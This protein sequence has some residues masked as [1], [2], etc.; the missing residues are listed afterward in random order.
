[1][2]SI[3]APLIAAGADGEQVQYRQGIVRAWNPE[4]G[5]NTI[6][7]AG[8]ILTDLPF[9]S[10]VEALATQVGDVVG[11]LTVR[12]Q[13]WIIGRIQVTP[14]AIVVRDAAGGVS[15]QIDRTPAGGGQVTTFH[16]NGTLHGRLGELTNLSTGERVG[17]GFLVQKDD[18]TD[19]LGAAPLTPDG[20]VLVQIRDDDGNLTVSTSPDLGLDRPYLDIPMYPIRTTPGDTPWAVDDVASF[21]TVWLG[22]LRMTHPGLHAQARAF[23]TTGTGEIRL[24]VNGQQVGSTQTVSSTTASFF[25]FGTSIHDISSLLPHYN[26]AA[27]EIQARATS[28]ARISVSP[29]GITKRGL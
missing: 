8:G 17:Q 10:T 15:V 24:I 2:V 26:F 16:P 9:L 3:I 1:M 22:R 27:V 12:S 25:D 29:Y 14:G 19:I 20:P 11:V 23:A 18:D 7:V 28:G 4:T 5:D 6:E 13:W 21:I